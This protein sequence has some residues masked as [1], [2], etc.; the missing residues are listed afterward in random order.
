MRELAK[1]WFAIGTQS[2]GGG[3]ST[4]MLIRRHIVERHSWVTRRQFTE[5]W[6]L[7][8]L[9]PG[10]HLVALAGLLGKRIAGW[11]GVFVSVA[12]MMVPAG[13]VTTLMTAAYGA[14][15][16]HPLAHAALA[17]MGPATGGMT[18]AL[19]AILARDAGRRGPVAIVDGAVV[20]IAFALLTFTAASSVVVILVA[21]GAGALML[22]RQRP[23][24]ERGGV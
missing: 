9:S 10:I 16:D 19:A 11:R 18:I 3:A 2:V 21:A 22:G 15:A 13:I 20:L 12:A 6:A 5:D 1:A 24:S 17:G 14:V 8:Q 4:L 23:T 7:S